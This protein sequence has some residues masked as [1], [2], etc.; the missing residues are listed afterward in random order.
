M[1]ALVK[2]SILAVGAEGQHKSG[3][4]PTGYIQVYSW[5]Q[6]FSNGGG[7][8]NNNNNN[9]IPS[10]QW[11]PKGSR[12]QGNL[13]TDTDR[14]FGAA[15]ALAANGL[16]L[17]VGLSSQTQSSL[18]AAR[19]LRFDSRKEAWVQEGDTLVANSG[20]RASVQ[21]AISADGATIATGIVDGPGTVLVYKLVG[22]D[23]HAVGEPLRG[24]QQ[25]DNFGAALALSADGNTLVVGASQHFVRG[26]SRGYVQVFRHEQQQQQQRYV[27]FGSQLVGV[28][29]RDHFG[30]DVGGAN[31]GKTLA[32]AAL[33]G[34]PQDRGYVRT[35]TMYDDDDTNS[36]NLNWKPLGNDMPVYQ[37]DGRFCTSVAMAGNVPV[38][39][40]GTTAFENADSK[41]FVQL[42]ET[43][44][45]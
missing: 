13:S 36:N 2:H 10:G 26:S 44:R 27:P 14:G 15:V 20:N 35:Y 8:N 3:G 32:V 21:V 30:W 6:E 40:S 45:R 11:V 31:D 22:N 42:F 9:S 29:G 24:T 38:V 16:F 37:E 34:G 23:W 25:G 39:A 19:I 41:G 33:R 18:P 17:V 5:K 43:T 4:A 1:T 12:L 28:A 7:N